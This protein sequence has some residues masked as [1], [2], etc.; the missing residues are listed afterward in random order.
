VGGLNADVVSLE[1][2]RVSNFYLRLSFIPLI[3]L[4]T[5]L[6]L[7]RTQPHD[8]HEL[9]DLLLPDG[10]PAPC[11]IGIRPGVTTMLEARHILEASGWTDHVVLNSGINLT[12]NDSFISV[13]W[14]WNDQRSPLLDAATPAYMLSF[15]SGSDAVVDAI[16]ISTTVPMGW[17]PLLMQPPHRYRFG[18]LF[19]KASITATVLSRISTFY[20][21]IE[22]SVNLVCPLKISDLWALKTNLYFYSQPP[23]NADI[24][25]WDNLTISRTLKSACRS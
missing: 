23:V 3:L 2:S 10:C 15:E 5:A 18:T 13:S 17:M 14:D 24:H 22:A 7:I 6:L 4:S 25:A 11:F 20:N 16:S 1:E 21:R 19:P 12:A 8:D 9:R